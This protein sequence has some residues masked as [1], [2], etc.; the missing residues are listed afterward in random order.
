MTP[1]ITSRSKE[2]IRKEIEETLNGD[3]TVSSRSIWEALGIIILLLFLL[4]GLAY[5][6]FG[7]FHV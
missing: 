3:E 1:K 5:G 2:E 6:I 7:G 4:G